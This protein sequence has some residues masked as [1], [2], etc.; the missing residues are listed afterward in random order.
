MAQEKYPTPRTNEGLTQRLGDFDTLSEALD[1]AA[2]GETGC[3]F[4]SPRGK[5]ETVLP[6]SDLREMAI[7]AGRRLLKLGLK[8][9][10]RV[11]IVAETTPEFMS[12]FFGCQYAGLIPCALPY[13]M[14]MGGSGAY[15]LRLQ[16][17]LESAGISAVFACD[18]LMDQVREAAMLAKTPIVLSHDELAE[19][20]DREIDLCPFLPTDAAYIQYSSGSTSNPKGVLITQ[21]AICANVRGILNHG[22]CVTPEDRAASWLPLYHDMGLVGFFLSTLMGQVSIDYLAT[23]AF[24][25]RPLQWLKIMSDNQTTVTYSPSFGYDLATRRANGSAGDFDLSSLRVA[26]IGGDMVRHDVLGAFAEKFAVANFDRRA[27]LAS[28]G[29]AEAS[30]AVSFAPLE[31]SYEVDLIDRT[32][33][34]MSRKAVCVDDNQP[35]HE[36]R[37]RAFIKCGKPLPGHKMEVRGDDGEL[38]GPR[39][40]GHIM[41]SGPSL[42]AGYFQ[43]DEAT[44][45]VLD[46]DGWLKT[47]DMGYML[48]GEIVITGRSKDLI[49]HNGRNIWPQDIEWAVEKI[50]PLRSGDAAAFAIEAANDDE[51]VVVLAQCRLKDDEAQEELRRQIAAIVHQQAGVEVDVVLVPPRSLPFTSSGKLSRA[52]AKLR[53]LSGEIAEISRKL[54]ADNLVV[55][56]M[57]MV[58]EASK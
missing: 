31:T 9:G 12:V 17:M 46:S 22:L 48:D 8:R 42:M 45:A 24:A 10:D 32:L 39:E 44:D 56:Q 1:Y 27:F 43:N 30:L 5:L 19:V 11:G 51:Q 40:I 3:N 55:P 14:T 33:Y 21:K 20:S 6:Y 29:M 13:S 4:Y 25:R 52:G 49:L 23:S 47:G 15:V 54:I 53:F 18:A 50:D 58:S 41:I 57:G 37:S 38:L 16:G 28:Y 36:E 7:E 2:R 26:G 34:K 35:M